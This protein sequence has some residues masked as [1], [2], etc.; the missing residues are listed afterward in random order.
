MA[1]IAWQ[2]QASCVQDQASSSSSDEELSTACLLGA[3]P[4]EPCCI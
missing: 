3:H 4:S 1:E 2:L